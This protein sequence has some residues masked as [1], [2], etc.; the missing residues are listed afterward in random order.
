MAETAIIR[1]LIIDRYRSIKRLEWNPAPTMNVILGGGDVGKTTILEP[2]SLLLVPDVSS[3]TRRIRASP[4]HLICCEALS[5][6]K[7]L[8]LMI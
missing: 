1:R 2:V 5:T 8:A 3:T 4:R 7:P 6:A